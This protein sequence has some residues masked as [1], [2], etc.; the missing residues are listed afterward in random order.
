MRRFTQVAAKRGAR[1]P[2]MRTLESL[3]TDLPEI[4]TRFEPVGQ[5]QTQDTVSTSGSQTPMTPLEVPTPTIPDVPTPTVFTV[6]PP[7]VPMALQAPPPPMPTAHP[8]PA[9]VAVVA[10]HSVPPT[11]PLTA[12]TYADPAVPPAAPAPAYAI[13]PGVP[14]P[15]TWAEACETSF[16]DLKRRL[17]SVPIL[18]LPSRED[19]FMLYTNA[20]LQ[21]LGVVL[22]QHGRV[23]SY[24]S[25]WLKE[26]E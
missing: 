10:P 7:P 24:A 2:R 5:G 25:R 16:Q 4:P 9:P 26:H 22:M 15:F 14:P 6:P 18:V 21:G 20:S 19:G 13:A 1:R 23:V 12:A 3:A 11:V 17:V 8:T